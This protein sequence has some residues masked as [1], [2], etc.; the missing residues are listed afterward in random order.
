MKEIWTQ[1]KELESTLDL[2]PWYLDVIAIYVL[3]LILT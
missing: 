1:F 3:A 2:P